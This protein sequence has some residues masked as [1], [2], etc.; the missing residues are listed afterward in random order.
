MKKIFLLLP[1]VALSM[2]SCFLASLV[3]SVPTTVV[4]KEQPAVVVTQPA[5]QTVVTQ[6]NTT[7]VVTAPPAVNTAM[8]LDL[9]AVAAA[10]AQ[11]SSVRQFEQMLNSSAYMIN[12]LDLNRDGFIDYIRVL[13]Q[14]TRS[15]V[16]TFL[17]QACVGPNTFTDVATI[18]SNGSSYVRVTGATAIYG[19]NCYVQPTYVRTPAIYSC[20][21]QVNYTIWTSPYYYNNYPSYYS[22]PQ[23]YELSHYQ[24]YCNTYIS[25]SRYLHE[26]KPVSHTQT[27]TTAKREPIVNKAGENSVTTQKPTAGQQTA[28]P[29]QHTTGHGQSATPTNTQIKRT[30]TVADNTNSRTTTTNVRN[31]GRVNTTVSTVTQHGNGTQTVQTTRT[32]STS[33]GSTTTTSARTTTGTTA[34]TTAGTTTTS[35][36]TTGHG[37]R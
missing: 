7:T 3:T 33:H 26:D 11:S 30:S 35:S 25:N 16:H 36:R 27:T 14:P 5:V 8:Y 34:R 10:F 17:L 32:T 4:V 12:N 13:E 9:N 18:T 21:C 28:A 2:Q 15:G 22:R 23:C 29:A 20:L 1:T 6:H 24:A 19:A 31:D 37:Q